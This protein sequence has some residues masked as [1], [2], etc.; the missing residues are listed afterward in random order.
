MN[1]NNIDSIINVKDVIE[2]NY[3]I[4]P[5]NN[6][7]ND[8]ENKIILSGP[9]LKIGDEKNIKYVSNF[10]TYIYC[11]EINGLIGSFKKENFK[12]LIISDMNANQIE[13]DFK[14]V[15]IYSNKIWI[16]M[17]DTTSVDSFKIVTYYQKIGKSN[18]LEVFFKKCVCWFVGGAGDKTSFAGIEATNI[19]D[20][21]KNE[22]LK[23]IDPK[24]KNSVITEYLGYEELFAPKIFNKYIEKL[25]DNQRCCI[26]IIGHSLGGW[27]SAHFTNVL[28]YKNYKVNTLITID[29]VGIKKL[30]SIF[31]SIYSNYPIPFKE[32]WI[33]VLANP[34]ENN[35]SDEIAELGGR[36]KLTSK[37]NVDIFYDSSLNHEDANGMFFSI[38]SDKNINPFDLL[39][40]SIIGYL[41]KR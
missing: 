6:Y 36:W 32:T 21:L 11:C 4:K 1:I 27:N 15:Q 28:K 16:E 5:S 33:N 14:Y 24:I 3:K 2:S 13:V 25:P 39:N 29:P 31:T 19:M 37:D 38:F 41:T 40:I 12:C 17:K 30:T 20:H 23:R 22:F 9:Y 26:N 10:H 8:F 7:I 34:T 18:Y 35:A